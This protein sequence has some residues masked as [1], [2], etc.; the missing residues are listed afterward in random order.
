[1]S[2]FK[3][4]PVSKSQFKSKSRWRRCPSLPPAT[5]ATVVSVS[6]AAAS[7]PVGLQ[8]RYQYRYYYFCYHFY[9]YYYY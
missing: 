1:M 9:Y 6:Q 2:N 5:L 3:A 8:Y 7:V 4:K